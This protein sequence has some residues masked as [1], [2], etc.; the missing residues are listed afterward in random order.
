MFCIRKTFGRNS[1]KI[2]IAGFSLLEMMIVVALIG[3]LTA[4]C[5]PNYSHHI[6]REK[7]F[8]AEAHLLR[9]AAAFE[10]YYTIHNTY[11]DMTLDDAE[12]PEFI[13]G[14]SYRL[15]IDSSTQHDFLISANPL[16]TQAKEDADCGKLSLNSALEKMSEGDSKEC[17]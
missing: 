7:R 16:N 6:T 12:I 14:K 5:V 15:A 17:W 8:E 3:I 2:K 10:Q 4:I 9:L 13:A 11:A 1:F